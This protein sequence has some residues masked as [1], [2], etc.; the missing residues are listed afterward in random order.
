MFV[1]IFNVSPTVMLNF[2]HVAPFHQSCLSGDTID[3]CK[4]HSVP[5][6]EACYLGVTVL[7]ETVIFWELDGTFLI[8]QNCCWFEVA[9]RGQ[10]H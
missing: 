6:F 3:V 10:S 5:H 9:V 4:V 7:L 1:H 8:F 2:I